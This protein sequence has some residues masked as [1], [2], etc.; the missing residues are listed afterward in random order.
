MAK[1]YGTPV[2]YL[3]WSQ[4]SN[5]YLL[6]N[7]QY[8]TPASCIIQ[9]PLITTAPLR[10]V[11]NTKTI[12]ENS[13]EWVGFFRNSEKRGIFIDLYL[14]IWGAIEKPGTIM[15]TQAFIKNNHQEK[16]ET[17]KQGDSIILC[18][19]FTRLFA[20]CISQF[21]ALPCPTPGQIFKNCHISSPP[22]QFFGLIPRAGL[23]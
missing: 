20:L 16:R 5:L 9:L 10:Y 15:D 2:G 14:E 17:R 8:P 19:S 12:F 21:Q 6:R 18:Q 11:W 22:G 23:P 1:I 7:L 3:E 13:V 4:N